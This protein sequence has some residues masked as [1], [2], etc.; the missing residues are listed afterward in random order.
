MAPKMVF[1]PHVDA[2][3]CADRGQASATVFRPL[4]GT[5]LRLLRQPFYA[6]ARLNRAARDRRLFAEISPK[7]RRDIGFHDVRE[8]SRLREGENVRFPDWT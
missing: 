2:A 6:L 4:L 5:M 3:C 1:V 8:Q 7:L